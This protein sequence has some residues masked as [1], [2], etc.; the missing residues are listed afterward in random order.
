MKVFVAGATGVIGRATVPLLLAAGHEVTGLARS[1]GAARRL[2][3]A[4]ARAARASLFDPDGLRRAVAGHDAVV[5]LATAIPS[6]S[7]ATKAEAWEENNRVRSEGSTNLVAAARAAGAAVYVQESVAFLYADH[8]DQWV[9]SDAGLADS[10]W[11]DAVRRAEANAHDFADGEGRG[12]VLRFGGFYT[13]DSEHTRLLYRAA[14]RGFSLDLGRHDAYFPA[15][16]VDDAA[17]AVVAA[18]EAPSGTYDVVDSEPMTRCQQAE[19]WSQALGRRVRRLPVWLGRFA[20]VAGPAG[21]RSMRVSNRRFRAATG[22]APAFPG[23]RSSLPVIVDQLGGP[24]ERLGPV[25]RASLWVLFLVGVT[26][27][28][29]AELG[30]R[31]FFDEFPFSRGWV[32][33]DGPYNEHLVR[34]YGAMNLALAT[35]VLGALL[36]GTRVLAATAAAAWLVFGVPHLVYHL[37]HLDLYDG[38]DVAGNVVGTAATAVLPLVALLALAR[39][40]RDRAAEGAGR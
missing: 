19:V 33:A 2:E 4:G 10:I 5:N 29:W 34:D 21:T 17:A 37:H 7:D 8:G 16:H 3:A 27:G 9:P 20:G 12:V 6:G 26:L 14:R 11:T 22:W 30:P 23:V 13:A 40:G 1:A 15:I 38:A 39:P 25:V 32:A 36:T 24:P 31:H 18:L 35:V 28:V